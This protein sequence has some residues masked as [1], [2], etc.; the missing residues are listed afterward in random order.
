MLF[1]GPPRR[2]DGHV[3]LDTNQHRH[4][5]PLTTNHSININ[6]DATTN[7]TNTK[8][9]RLQH[10]RQHQHRYLYFYHQHQNLHQHYHHQHTTNTNIT[11]PPTHHHLPPPTPP[12]TPTTLPPPT[13]HQH[14]HKHHQH[15]PTTPPPPTYHQH[16]HHQ[17]GR[18]KK[19]RDTHAGEVR[20]KRC[21]IPVMRTTVRRHCRENLTSMSLTR[22]ARDRSTPTPLS[23]RLPH[24]RSPTS[25]VKLPP[26]SCHGRKTP[27]QR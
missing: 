19:Q 16:Q 18:N 7:T 26:R 9:E 27:H 20:V 15:P 2:G 13:R 25:N 17:P 22:D 1:Y 11:R 14:H 4:N 12:P 10:Q 23:L 6:T 3:G 24:E 5:Q 21:C 8:P